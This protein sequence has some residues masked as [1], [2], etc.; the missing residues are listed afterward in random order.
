[1][2]LKAQIHEDR[3]TGLWGAEL[4]AFGL[5]TQGT[6]PD[7][8]LMMLYDAVTDLAP[9]LAFELSWCDKSHGKALLHTNEDRLLIDTIARQGRGP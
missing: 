5:Y 6:S 7:E 3:A 2:E 4:S 9:G 8:A 1:M